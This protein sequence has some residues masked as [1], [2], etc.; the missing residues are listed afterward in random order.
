MK[1]AKDLTLD[2]F[3]LKALV[4][5]GSGTG[6]TFFAASCPKTAF[7]NCEPN[8]LDTV[9]T[10]PHLKAN[11]ACYEEFIPQNPMDTKRVFSEMYK[12]LKEVRELIAKGEVETVILDNLTYLTENRWVYIQNYEASVSKSGEID[13]RGMYG[14][15]GRWLYTFV[16]MELL[17]L[18]CNLIVTCHEKLESDDALKKKPD[19]TNPIIANVLGGFRDTAEGLFSL[20]LYLN[21]IPMGNNKYKYMGRTNRGNSRNGKNRFGLS[22]VVENISYPVIIGEIRKKLGN[23][24]V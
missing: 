21:K 12:Y 18:P 17:S 9:I 1:T 11:L 15:L 3:K 2:N 10:N 23:V 16:L 8:G 19:K 6:K 20:V 4:I 24:K 14:I 22:E 5:G 13:I 7:I